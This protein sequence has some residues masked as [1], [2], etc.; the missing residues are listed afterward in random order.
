MHG[1]LST[2]RPAF[3]SVWAMDICCSYAV[4]SIN[5]YFA[6]EPHIT[7]QQNQVLLRDI[8]LWYFYSP[9]I[10]CVRLLIFAR[11]IYL[12][13]SCILHPSA[14]FIVLVTGNNISRLG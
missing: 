11:V 10:F 2:H 3:T 1:F 5:N 6:T 8:F 7:L 9:F 12:Y 13:H 4:Q 14:S